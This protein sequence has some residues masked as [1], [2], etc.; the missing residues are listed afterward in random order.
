MEVVVQ[1]HVAQ[2]EVCLEI[3][4]IPVGFLQAFG[5]GAAETVALSDPHAVDGKEDVFHVGGFL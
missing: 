4:E 2:L 5:L 1:H 3:P